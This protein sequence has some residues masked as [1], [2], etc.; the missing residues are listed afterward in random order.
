M[1]RFA[2][3]GLAVVCGLGAAYIGSTQPAHACYH[4]YSAGSRTAHGC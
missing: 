3:L 4:T 2:F 1:L